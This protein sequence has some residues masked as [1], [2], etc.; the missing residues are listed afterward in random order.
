MR[1]AIGARESPTGSGSTRV[2]LGKDAVRRAS[3]IWHVPIRCKSNRRVQGM[4]PL[5][6][7]PGEPQYLGTLGGAF[8]GYDPASGW[9]RFLPWVFGLLTLA[10]LVLVVLH[11]GTIEQFARLALAVQP[12][13]FILACV[14]QAATYVSASLVWRQAL[15]RSG[16]PRSLHALVPLG[17]AKLF[18][19]RRSRCPMP[20]RPIFCGKSMPVI[21]R[22]CRWSGRDDGG[23]PRPGALRSCGCS[24]HRPHCDPAATSSWLASRAATRTAQISRLLAMR[25]V[26]AAVSVSILAPPASAGRVAFKA[27]DR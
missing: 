23:R 17:I 9:R 18:D 8:P 11:F 5:R 14:A 16:Y 1:S 21:R 13:W 27:P 7:L 15:C 26:V 4:T 12:E 10:A 25:L 20:C 22:G 19:L 6:S 24:G 2:D 3:E